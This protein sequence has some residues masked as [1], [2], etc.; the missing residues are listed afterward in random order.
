MINFRSLGA[1]KCI[2]NSHDKGNSFAYRLVALA[3]W[4]GRTSQSTRAYQPHTSQNVMFWPNE[5]RKN[6]NSLTVQCV[7][8]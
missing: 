2:D 5:L 3:D 6:L 4:H 1:Y 7:Q 8:K